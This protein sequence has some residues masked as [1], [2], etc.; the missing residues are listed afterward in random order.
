LA[1]DTTVVGEGSTN[2]VRAF[3]AGQAG[4]PAA[5][6]DSL[7]GPNP[8]GG[9]AWHTATGRA[10]LDL[11]IAHGTGWPL[12]RQMESVDMLCFR[13]DL[14]RLMLLARPKHSIRQ[15]KYHPMS[16]CHQCSPRRAE[17]ALE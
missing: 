12:D 15:M 11:R 3:S 1:G 2:D 7:S 9:S 16:N 14:G 5:G 8:A 6:N 17:P 10:K 13:C 4:M